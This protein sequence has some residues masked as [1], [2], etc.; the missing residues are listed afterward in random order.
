VGLPP[1]RVDVIAVLDDGS[2]E[3]AVEHLK[4]VG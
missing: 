2:G 4:G 1:C 3:P